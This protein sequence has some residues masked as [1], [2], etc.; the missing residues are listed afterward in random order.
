VNNEDFD[1]KK[2]HDLD[3]N[4]NYKNAFLGKEG[5]FN[6]YIILIG[7]FYIGEDF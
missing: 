1:Q 3:E 4:Y 7:Q 5:M 2:T 6:E